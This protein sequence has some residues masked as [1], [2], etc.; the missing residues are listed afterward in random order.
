MKKRILASKATLS[1]SA[2]AAGTFAVLLAASP[3]GDGIAMAEDPEEDAPSSAVDKILLALPA[4]M[5][6]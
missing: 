6:L 1:A 5:E 3:F 4:W 2:V